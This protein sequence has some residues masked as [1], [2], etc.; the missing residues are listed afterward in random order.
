MYKYKFRVMMRDY[1]D[2]VPFNFACIYTAA[3]ANAAGKSAM[4]EWDNLQ[5]IEIKRMEYTDNE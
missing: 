3:N 2:G 4:R 1:V 5:M